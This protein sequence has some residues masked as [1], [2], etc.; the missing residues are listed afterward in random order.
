MVPLA[1]GVLTEGR[2]VGELGE[3][4]LGL[5]RGRASD[6]EI[7]V[8]KSLGVATQDLVLGARLLDLAEQQGFGLEFDEKNA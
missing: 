4:L 5:K 7:T 6:D 8:F 2:I 1:S 3:T